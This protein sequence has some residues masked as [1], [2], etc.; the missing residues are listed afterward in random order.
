MNEQ[1]IVAKELR[2]HEAIYQRFKTI[3]GIADKNKVL[4]LDQKRG[5]LTTLNYTEEKTEAEKIE[6][7]SNPVFDIYLELFEAIKEKFLLYYYIT[8]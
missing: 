7:S 5:R 3:A 4:L 1:G 8:L 2:E 6:Y